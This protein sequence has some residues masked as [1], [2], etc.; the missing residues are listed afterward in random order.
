MMNE[1][2]Q[3]AIARKKS[4]KSRVQSNINYNQIEYKPENIVTSL[5]LQDSP[6]YFTPGSPVSLRSVTPKSAKSN[7]RRTKSKGK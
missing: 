3:L 7:T 1:Q 6:L 5:N 4:L 2:E